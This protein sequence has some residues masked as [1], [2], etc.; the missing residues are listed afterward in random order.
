[1]H[2]YG[3]G[4]LQY[5]YE[6][7]TINVDDQEY[8]FIVAAEQLTESDLIKLQHYCQC[9]KCTANWWNLSSYFLC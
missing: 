4:L 9:D 5:R 2:N 8:Q 1:M 3:H 7:Y 6:R